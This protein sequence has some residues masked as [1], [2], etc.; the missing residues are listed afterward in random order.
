MLSMLW[1]GRKPAPPKSAAGRQCFT[2]ICEVREY[3][4]IKSGWPLP[5]SL[6]RDPIFVGRLMAMM[7]MLS[8][9]T[10]E[11]ENL[12]RN[13]EDLFITIFGDTY[14]PW[15]TNLMRTGAENETLVNALEE[16][17]AELPGNSNAKYVMISRLGSPMVDAFKK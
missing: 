12:A 11:S 4:S 10:G 17:E 2:V 5:A 7:D 6:A 8:E 14:G 15:A 3:F 9:K 16:L 1:K 13:C